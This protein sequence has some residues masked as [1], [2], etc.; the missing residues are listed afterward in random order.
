M[1]AIHDR[2][3]GHAVQLAYGLK[4]AFMIGLTGQPAR[5][6]YVSHSG[7]VDIEL[8]MSVRDTVRA[9]LDDPATLEVLMRALER[10]VCPEMVE[11]RV[12]LGNCYASTQARKLAAL[13]CA[14]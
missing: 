3:A 12:A 2:A 7:P 6:P 1:S 9:C 4:A 5:L 14:S 10:S 13:R 11:L 8:E